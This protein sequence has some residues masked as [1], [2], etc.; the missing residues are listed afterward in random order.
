MTLASTHNHCIHVNT[1]AI[2]TSIANNRITVHHFFIIIIIIK[3]QDRCDILTQ[4]HAAS[5]QHFC[6]AVK[7][8][9]VLHYTQRQKYIVY[10]TIFPAPLDEGQKK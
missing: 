3:K 10:R 5:F 1:T 8:N 7:G 2:N 9:T 6:I 4:T